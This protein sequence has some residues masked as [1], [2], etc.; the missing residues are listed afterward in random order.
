MTVSQEL[1]INIYIKFINWIWNIF[2]SRYKWGLVILWAYKAIRNLTQ[3]CGILDK[4][5]YNSETH[6]KWIFLDRNRET[7]MPDMKHTQ[8]NTGK[9][10]SNKVQDSRVIR[11]QTS[12]KHICPTFNNCW[13]KTKFMSTINDAP[14]II[15]YFSLPNISELFQTHIISKYLRCLKR[16]CA[17]WIFLCEG[18]TTL[19]HIATS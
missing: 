11:K 7:L 19:F 14:G 13:L 12:R 6:S 8:I 18:E 10:Q 3:V 16:R 5:W 15:S 17:T 2:P 4:A 1:L 9:W